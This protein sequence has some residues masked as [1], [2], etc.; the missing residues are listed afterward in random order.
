VTRFL[1]ANRP[2]P[3]KAGYG[4]RRP[5]PFRL[6]TLRTTTE[7]AMAQGEHLKCRNLAKPFGLAICLLLA[8][9]WGSDHPNSSRYEY[10]YV[11][12]VFQGPYKSF[13]VGIERSAWKCFDAKAQ[14]EF[15]CTMVRGGWEHFQYIYRERRSS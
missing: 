15:N 9:C 4:Q 2:S 14:K 6:K 13:P 12:G 5:V 7:S 8:G 1:H 10:L 11:N 3:D